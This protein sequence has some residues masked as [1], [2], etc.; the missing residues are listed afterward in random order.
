[1]RIFC[2]SCI[3]AEG[4][5]LKF[6]PFSYLPPQNRL[7]LFYRHYFAFCSVSFF[8]R[9]NS[10]SLELLQQRICKSTKNKYFG[11]MRTGVAT[12]IYGRLDML[13]GFVELYFWPFFHHIVQAPFVL[14][15]EGKCFGGV[16]CQTCL[17]ATFK[18]FE[19]FLVVAFYPS[20]G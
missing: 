15:H 6:F 16:I 10:G 2:S 14:G 17:V 4:R 8:S 7:Y 20:C 19:F 1:L 12:Q 11:I 13:A 9:Q 18:F 3:L 5:V